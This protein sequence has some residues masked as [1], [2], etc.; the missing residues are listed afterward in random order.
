MLLSDQKAID[1]SAVRGNDPGVN[2]SRLDIVAEGDLLK[3][4]TEGSLTNLLDTDGL[5]VVVSSGISRSH[6]LLAAL[7]AIPGT[8]GLHVASESDLAFSEIKATCVGITGTNGKSTV[9]KLVAHLVSRRYGT[10]QP[11]GNYGEPLCDLATRPETYDSL[12]V[13]LSSFQLAS[14]EDLRF[15]VGVITNFAP[16]HESWHGGRTEYFA[17]K[18]RLCDFLGDGHATDNPRMK[19]AQTANVSGGGPWLVT[20]T[21]IIKI[22]AEL[23]LDVPPG[24]R[25][26]LVAPAAEAEDIL[27]R[28]SGFSRETE[29]YFW[30]RQGLWTPAASGRRH[31][32]ESWKTLG[33]AGD[34]N[35][36]NAALSFL[37]A[38][39]FLELR[40]NSRTG[41]GSAFNSE[42]LT[43]TDFAGFEGLPHRYQ[44]VEG[45]KKFRAIDDSK[46]TNVDA[47]LA[48]LTST[49]GQV[50]LLLGGISK[51]ESFEPLLA[52][53][54][55]IRALVCFG[56]SGKMIAEEIGDRMA[57]THLFPTLSA[58]LDQIEAF[59]PGTGEVLL[60]S[61]G[62]ASFDEFRNYAHR[63][64]Y[65]VGR[66]LL[67]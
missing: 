52:H 9:T 27:R 11:G 50:T 63:G 32:I 47:V 19:Q 43:D 64:D 35:Y 51:G 58:A 1:P 7:T 2:L 67:A 34:H 18:W 55:K 57:R 46:A 30:D 45:Q 12:A 25:T 44:P 26:A 15:Q 14:S 62:C 29:L 3:A 60:F 8:R 59:I 40:M 13:E 21:A 54:S 65:F 5:T 36:F 53:K 42:A 31:I 38:G 23:G 16:D 17:A 37:A 6:P 61:P 48:A 4:A 41:R 10:C 24:V 20:S 33:L 56:A 49:D 22:A 28:T 39:K 66:V